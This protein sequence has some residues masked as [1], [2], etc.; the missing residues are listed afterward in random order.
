LG[1]FC[2]TRCGEDGGADEATKETVVAG[3]AHA[4]TARL[5][6]QFA[7]VIVGS[8]E[9]SL[10]RRRDCGIDFWMTK[11][12]I[13]GGVT[14]VG[15]ASA[16]GTISLTLP[17]NSGAMT[18]GTRYFVST[19]PNA[20][21]Y[22]PMPIT[23]RSC[24]IAAIDQ[25][26]GGKGFPFPSLVMLTGKP[27]VGK[28]NLLRSMALGSDAV[29]FDCFDDAFDDAFNEW[30]RSPRQLIVGTSPEGNIGYEHT[31]DIVLRLL[32]RGKDRVLICEK[33]RFS[34][35]PEGRVVFETVPPFVRYVLPA[36]VFKKRL[37][38][39]E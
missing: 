14:Y 4:L 3:R 18:A 11:Q 38:D 13:C 34:R 15:I 8:S 31:A 24:G 33:N 9:A 10:P 21:A 1:C 35:K 27:G 20:P 6:K 5:A 23:Y 7:G 37:A 39:H 12:I 19:E 26:L 17:V 28:A 22:S 29:I 2:S 30:R 36:R 16:P 32:P 25:L